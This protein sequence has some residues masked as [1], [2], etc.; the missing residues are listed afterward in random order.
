MGT[1]RVSSMNY[2]LRDQK[3]ES[4]C[5]YI[6]IYSDVQTAMENP[7]P[8]NFCHNMKPVSSPSLTHQSAFCLNVTFRQCQYFTENAVKPGQAAPVKS[9]RNKRKW[10]PLALVAFACIAILGV[11]FVAGGQ[12][13]ALFFPPRADNGPTPVVETAIA[14][15][16]P[17]TE[18]ALQEIVIEPEMTEPALMTEPAVMAESTLVID[19]QV[20]PAASPTPIPTNTGES[21]QSPQTTVTPERAFLLHRVA[22]GEDLIAIA[23]K[24][25][26]SVEA[27]RAVNHNM[28]PELW[29]DT[30]I[31]I[32]ENQADVTGVAPMIPIE[33]TGVE[34]TVQELAEEY[35]VSADL[36]AAVNARTTSY[37]F[38]IGD[39]VIIPQ[40]VLSPT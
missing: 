26:T 22:R 17:A 35:A 31:V 4:I 38:Q 39:W 6:G 28:A 10:M 5:P 7:S 29:V 13:R 3:I 18:P 32:P 9:P 40:A 30:M 33:I 36:L 16:V 2:I 8:Q 34:K 12:L 1:G 11:L 20:Q 24:Y 19:N 27:I 23:N 14:T 37:Q 21:A 15:Q 25:N